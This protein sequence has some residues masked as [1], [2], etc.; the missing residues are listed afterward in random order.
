[1]TNA[2]EGIVKGNDLK[3]MSIDELW[4]LHEAVTFELSQKLAAEKSKL[5]QRLCEL[6]ERIGPQPG[7]ATRQ[8]I[9]RS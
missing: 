4:K 6:N 1:M 5:E 2:R 9:R 7:G 8:K 3:A